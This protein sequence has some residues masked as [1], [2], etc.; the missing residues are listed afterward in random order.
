MFQIAATAALA[1]DNND[2]F[3]I[4]QFSINK[5]EWPLLYKQLP[6]LTD[7]ERQS[8][9]MTY[10]EEDFF[11]KK[12]PYMA[13]LKLHGYFQSEKYFAHHRP[14]IIELFKR[15]WNPSINREVLTDLFGP[16]ILVGVHVRRGDYLSHPTKFLSPTKEWLEKCIWEMTRQ[17]HYA[18]GDYSPHNQGPAFGRGI[19]FIFFSDDIQWCKEN[20]PEHTYS[21]GRGPLDDMALMSYCDHQIMGPSSFSWWASWLNENPSKLVIAPAVWFGPGNA[22]LDYRDVVP[23]SWIK[24]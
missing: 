9:V 4:P 20:F 14:R 17:L 19:K 13:G 1:W 21:E 11:Y 12:I 23:D 16:R 3:R 7:E 5:K 15:E 2:E 18:N 6:T 22:H 8:V 24:L 10:R